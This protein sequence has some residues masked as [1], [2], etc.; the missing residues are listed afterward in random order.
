MHSCWLVSKLGI[1]GC[2]LPVGFFSVRVPS[3]WRVL[4][5]SNGAYILLLLFSHVFHKLIYTFPNYVTFAILLRLFLRV[6]KVEGFHLAAVSPMCTN[7]ILFGLAVHFFP[8]TY[9]VP[10]KN[11]EGRSKALQQSGESTRVERD[12]K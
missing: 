5:I 6:P 7:F 1:S 3:H 4:S 2:S 9:A 12:E 11:I 10:G 8:G